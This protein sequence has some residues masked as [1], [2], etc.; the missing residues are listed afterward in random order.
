MSARSS[1]VTCNWPGL[2]PS[3]LITGTTFN[4]VNYL[5][6][7]SPEWQTTVGQ[8]TV[9]K[10]PVGTAGGGSEGIARY[11]NYIKGSIGY[12]EL[13][14]AVSHKMT[15][16]KVRNRAGI[17]VAPSL[18]S[19]Q[20]AAA[21]AEWKAADFYELLTDA[22]GNDAWPIA[23]TV[24]V[25][26]PRQAHDTARAA[27]ALRFFRWSLENGQAEAKALNYVSLPDSLVKRVE[28]Y[29][30]SNIKTDARP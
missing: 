25:M 18:E 9:V 11:V 10:W 22:P 5:C 12:V 1:P 13:A 4:W 26:M 30:S 29:W 21:G 16:P 3:R 24:F 27:E 15:Y 23:A 14:Y 20:A 2:S 19:F 6:K 8:G 28:D 7:V 17:F